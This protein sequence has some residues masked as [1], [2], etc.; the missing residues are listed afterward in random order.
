[1]VVQHFPR[2]A[3]E[4]ADHPLRRGVAAPAGQAV[5]HRDHLRGSAGGGYL[6]GCECD[7][8]HARRGESDDEVPGAVSF[9]DMQ[10]FNVLEYGAVADGKT[11]N[12]E[13]FARALAAC[14]AAGRGRV[15]VS[16]G[17]YLTGPIRLIGNIDFHIE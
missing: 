1:R 10:T 2:L 14:A 3:G 9:R 11:K 13:A 6:V 12:T 5:L 16:P 17:T 4:G 7:H 8:R 15:L